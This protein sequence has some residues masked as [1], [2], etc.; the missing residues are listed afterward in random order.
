LDVEVGGAER[1]LPAEADALNAQ[2]RHNVVALAVLRRAVHREARDRYRRHVDET[3]ADD[4]RP[5]RHAVLREVVVEC[6]EARKVLRHEAAL[7]A[8]GVARK[9]WVAAA[10]GLVEAGGGVSGD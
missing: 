5:A 4:A 6:A 7:A 2:L 10:R 9:H 8:E 1:S 3:R